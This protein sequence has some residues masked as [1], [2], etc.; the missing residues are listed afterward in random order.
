MDETALFFR[1]LPDK[2]L[3]IK[4]QVCSGGKKAKNRL[5]LALIANA[6][7]DMHKTWVIGKFIKLISLKG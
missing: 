3:S 1:Q 7:G 2:T 5:T 6:A 4:G